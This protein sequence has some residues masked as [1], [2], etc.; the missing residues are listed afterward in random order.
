M[1]MIGT[2]VVNFKVLWCAGRLLLQR[3]FG[4]NRVR[5]IGRKRPYSRA[6]RC[7]VVKGMGN[8]VRLEYEASGDFP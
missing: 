1:R 3:V 5:V 8:P 7:P 4:E 6:I 2:I